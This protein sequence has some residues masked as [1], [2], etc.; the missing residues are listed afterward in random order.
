[1][2]E[3]MNEELIMLFLSAATLG[4]LVYVYYLLNDCSKI[5]DRML[6]RSKRMMKKLDKSI[7]EK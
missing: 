6:K 7:N 3:I 4:V 2:V 1:M 5:L